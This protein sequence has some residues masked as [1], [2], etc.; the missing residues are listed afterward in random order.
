MTL[1]RLSEFGRGPAVDNNP[2]WLP[3]G[4]VRSIIA[5]LLV[6]AAVGLAI[7][8]GN[9]DTVDTLAVAAVSFYFGNRSG[10]N[11]ANARTN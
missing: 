8:T 2:L 9:V 4:S 5:L 6:V 3:A 7:A 10:Q 11:D 1:S